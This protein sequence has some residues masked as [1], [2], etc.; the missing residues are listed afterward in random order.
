MNLGRKMQRN[1]NLRES[2]LDGEILFKKYF[3][4]GAAKTVERLR[5][6]AVSQGMKSKDGNDPTPMGV[7]K[8]MWRWASLKEN[9][10]KAWGIYSKNNPDK[11]WNDWESDLVSNMRTAWQHSNLAKYLRFLREND[12]GIQYL[13][14]YSDGNTSEFSDYQSAY[15][16]W[17]RVSKNISD[18]VIRGSLRNE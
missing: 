9:H 16:E 1:P 17:S 5:R 6:F 10:T 18:F 14:R 12:F 3:E 8:S 7:W 15:A 11:T 13:V 4:M 2:Y